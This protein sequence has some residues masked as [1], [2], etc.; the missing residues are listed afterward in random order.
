[1]QMHVFRVGSL[2][3]NCYLLWDDDREALLIDAGGGAGEIL[4]Y[5]NQHDLR[6]RY[7]VNTHGH[8]DHIAA[9]DAI[10]TATGA[11]LL[12]HTADA[13]WLSDIKLNLA[14]LLAQSYNPRAAD[15]LLGDGE[16]ITCSSIALQ[17]IHTP[18]HTPGGVCLLCEGMLF[19]GDTLFA[20]S[21]GRS[22][23]VGG[24]SEL[25]L[26]SIQERLLLL[27]DTLQ[28]YPGHGPATV[29]GEEKRSNP[30]IQL[31]GRMRL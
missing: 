15:I 16:K 9:N 17:V 31:P 4:R 6:L 8:H 25:L 7:L 21:I 23:L 13:S 1:M 5:I 28:V 10:V 12:I 19:S 27:D 30:Y 18:G 20:G 24:D 14:G 22:D 2:S 11:K 26:S 3:T 29:L